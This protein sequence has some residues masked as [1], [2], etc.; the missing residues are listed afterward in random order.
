MQATSVLSDRLWR[1]SVAAPLGLP[2]T[3]N[4]ESKNGAVLR[5]G[6]SGGA[7]AEEGNGARSEKAS[8]PAGARGGAAENTTALRHLKFEDLNRKVV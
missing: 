7:A 6:S 4:L 3:G 8:L 2:T 1:S 5:V